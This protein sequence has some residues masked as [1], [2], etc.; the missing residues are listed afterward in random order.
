MYEIEFS[1]RAYFVRI[2]L[3][4]IIVSLAF[5]C[6]MGNSMAYSTKRYHQQVQEVQ[7]RFTAQ[8]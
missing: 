7:M 5:L 3:L 4:M 2:G 8:K 1:K 6:Y